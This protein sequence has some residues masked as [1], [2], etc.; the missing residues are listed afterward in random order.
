MD[1]NDR[2]C[3]WDVMR[4]LDVAIIVGEESGD[5]LGYKLM[6][7]LK[8]ATGGAISF[9]GIGGSRMEQ[10]GFVSLFPLHE[11]AVMGLTAV[12]PRLPIIMRRAYQVIDALVATA[13]DLLIII[14]SPDFTHAVAKRVHTRMPYLPIVNYV[15]PS[16]WAW[17]P[18]RARKMRSYVDHVLALLPFE[19]EVHLKL[20]GPPCTYVGHPLIERLDEFTPSASELSA[21]DRSKD[22]LVLPGSRRAVAA[23]MLPIFRKTAENFPDATFTI[24]AVP[25]L[26]DWLTAETSTWSIP[27]RIVQGESE[28][29]KAFRQACCALVCSGTSSLELALAGVPMVVAYRVPMLEAIFLPLVKVPS[30]VL[31]NLII[32]Q[33][34][35]PEFLQ[36]PCRPEV[37][38]PALKDICGDTSKRA[39]QISAF[40]RLRELMSL[41]GEKPSHRAARI[42]LEVF[43][44]KT[45]RRAPRS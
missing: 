32:G 10:E 19:P 28:K 37:L 23:R 2:V 17:R 11:I 20:G 30:I 22:V 15:S 36:G 21:R 31:P 9:R 6:Q 13:P 18:G 1:R 3:G 26:A 12:L 44:Q 42:V 45:G 41:G 39:E 8:E 34:V 35:I 14:D 7:A 29:L 5:Q 27:V 33:N 43:E 25:T 38:R 4:S 40:S 24:P 16:V